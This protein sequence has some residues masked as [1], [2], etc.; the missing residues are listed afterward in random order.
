MRAQNNAIFEWKQ[1]RIQ[2]QPAP[3]FLL[4]GEFLPLRF[5]AFFDYFSSESIDS[6]LVLFIVLFVLNYFYLKIPVLLSLSLSFL[7][8]QKK[9]KFFFFDRRPRGIHHPLPGPS[10]PLSLLSKALDRAE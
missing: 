7:H 2:T 8:A 9:K 1:A 3:D 6:K 4:G 10:P 5:N